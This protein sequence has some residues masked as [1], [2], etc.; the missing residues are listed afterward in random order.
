MALCATGVLR[1]DCPRPGGRHVREHSG[2]KREFAVGRRDEFSQ[3][4]GE[5][6]RF[7]RPARHF[8]R[9]D[10]SAVLRVAFF[11]EHREPGVVR[12]CGLREPR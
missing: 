5:R 12:G 6:N 8:R 4:V 11:R 9:R 2:R 7:D 3:A 1:D 10:H